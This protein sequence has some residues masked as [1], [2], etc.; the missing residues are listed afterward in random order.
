MRADR[1]GRVPPGL[2]RGARPAIRRGCARAARG[3]PRPAPR[4]GPGPP[5]RDA[6][7]R[8]PRSVGTTSPPRPAR[9]PAEVDLA[10]RRP[11]AEAFVDADPAATPRSGPLLARLA[12]R[13]R[14]A[15]LSNWPLASTID[16]YVRAAG[17]QPDL[18]ARRRLPAGRHDQARPADLPGGRGGPRGRPRPRSS[19]W[20]TTGRPMS[21]GAIG[22][23][24]RAAYLRDRQ[25]G[26]PLPGSRPDGSVVADLV[27]DD[28]AELEAALSRPG[29]DRPERAWNA[30]GTLRCS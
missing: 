25:A 16:A 12:G 21:S 14:L 7:P 30:G 29:V 18:A 2:G 4:P 11:T 1:A 13:F 19:T 22:A 26:S 28:L 6:G 27:I 5:A 20:A 23:G 24:W 9:A 10:R 17:W 8:A 3:R 15:I